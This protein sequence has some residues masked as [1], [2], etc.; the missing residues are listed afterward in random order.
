MSA[1]RSDYNFPLTTDLS[2]W[3]KVT[4]VGKDI[5]IKS[6]NY[7]SDIWVS[8]HNDKQVYELKIDDKIH[9]ASQGNYN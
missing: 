3:G 9:P 1:W 7:E 6:D 4:K 2:K 8:I 5:L